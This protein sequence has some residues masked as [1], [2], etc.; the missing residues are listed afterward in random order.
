MWD[1][2][3]AGIEPVSPAFAGKFLT[4]DPLGKSRVFIFKFILMHLLF[5]LPTF[6]H[7][8]N[9]DTVHLCQHDLISGVT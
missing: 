1:L 2:P 6:S 3:G 5:M 7:N 9:T 8:F 4:T